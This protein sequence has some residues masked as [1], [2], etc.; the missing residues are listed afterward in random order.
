MSSGWWAFSP[1][2]PNLFCGF[3]KPGAVPSG[4][5]SEPALESWS[6]IKC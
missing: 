6:G 3:Y 2:L 1:R 4:L 5:D